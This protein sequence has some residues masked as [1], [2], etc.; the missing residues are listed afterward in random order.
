[1]NSETA[2]PITLPCSEPQPMNELDIEKIFK[3]E[4]KYADLLELCK[5]DFYWDSYII[6]TFFLIMWVKIFL[7]HEEKSFIATKDIFAEYEN[8]LISQNCM[9]AVL[10]ELSFCKEIYPALLAAKI[11]HTKGRKLGK[12]G[13]IGI[14]F[15][16]LKLK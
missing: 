7:K 16:S 15:S 9:D 5:K 13:I 10:T 2:N 3:I 4:L 11:F 6:K 1:M 14:N 8:F 12:R